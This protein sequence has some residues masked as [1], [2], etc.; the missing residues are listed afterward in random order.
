VARGFNLSH[1]TSVDLARG[2]VAYW[3]KDWPL[4]APER[5]PEQ[6]LAVQP[7][8]V[9]RLAGHCRA[10]AVLSAL[11]DERRIREAWQHPPR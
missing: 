5:L 10:N 9:S 11:G 1:G 3:K 7:D 6:I 8:D 2:L 4:T